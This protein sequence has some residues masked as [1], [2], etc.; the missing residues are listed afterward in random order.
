MNSEGDG[1][2]SREFQQSEFIDKIREISIEH[3]MISNSSG[4]VL[5]HTN[6]YPIQVDV[7]RNYAFGLGNAYGEASFRE[8]NGALIILFSDFYNY[9]GDTAEDLFSNLTSP[10]NPY[11]VNNVGGIYFYQ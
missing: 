4:F 9:Y 2:T 7:F 5:F 6:R 8:R 3:E 1:F 10:L 11:Y